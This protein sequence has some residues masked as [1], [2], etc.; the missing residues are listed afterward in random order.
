MSEEIEAPKAPKDSPMDAAKPAVNGY[1]MWNIRV[2]SWRA[3]KSH[4]E[5][6]SIKQ[7][8]I[9]LSLHRLNVFEGTQQR[10]GTARKR[11]RCVM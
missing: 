11:G 2:R 6:V 9:L 1:S 5:E 10:T 3:C 4:N 8:S 7:L